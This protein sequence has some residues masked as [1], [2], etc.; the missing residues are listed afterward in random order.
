MVGAAI[1]LCSPTVTAAAM[2]GHPETTGAAS[3]L[4]G[5]AQFIIGG[6]IGPIAGIGASGGPVLLGIVMTG[7]AVVAAALAWVA[8]RPVVR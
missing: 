7:C 2:Q 6:V 4:L 1:G 8:H 3:A 5:A